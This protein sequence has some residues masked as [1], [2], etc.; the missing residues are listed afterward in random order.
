[1]P[2]VEIRWSALSMDSLPEGDPEHPT[3]RH[4]C[5][6]YGA[7]TRIFLRK[8]QEKEGYAETQHL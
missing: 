7:I 1:M 5:H 3:L 4:Y 6:R 8:R 2:V